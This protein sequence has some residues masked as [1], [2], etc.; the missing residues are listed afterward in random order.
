MEA[1]LLW[2]LQYEELEAVPDT[3]KKVLL[4]YRGKVIKSKVTIQNG[5]M[6]ASFRYERCLG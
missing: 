4:S 3:D 1:G 2:I 6:K 5:K